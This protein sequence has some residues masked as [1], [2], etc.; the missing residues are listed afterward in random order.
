VLLLVLG[1]YIPPQLDSLMTQVAQS[2]EGT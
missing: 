1:I 2:L